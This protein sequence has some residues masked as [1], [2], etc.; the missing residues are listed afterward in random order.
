M[1]KLR[2]IMTVVALSVTTVAQQ[3]PQKHTAQSTTHSQNGTAKQ[4]DSSP[5][6]ADAKKS[7]EL[8]PPAPKEGQKQIDANKGEVDW[9]GRISNVITAVATL[10]LAVIGAIAACV[11]L[12]TLKEIQNQVGEMKGQRETME[13]QLKTMQS[14][15]AT[16]ERQTTHLETSVVVAQD[17]ASAARDNAIAAQEGSETA[18]QS[19][20]MFISKERARLRID[21]KP[22]KL[23]PIFGSIYAVD[24]AVC[25]YGATPAFVVE[26]RCTAHELPSSAIDEPELMDRAMLPMR[27][28]P[29]VMSPGAQPMESSAYLFFD[30]EAK[31]LMLSE[32]KADRFFVVVRGFIKYRDVF[33]C[34]RETKFRYVWKYSPYSPQT[35]PDRFGEWEK[36]GPA[37]DNIET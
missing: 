18:K 20:E 25:L 19:V 15:L 9:W 35:T 4:T 33:D 8:Q 2:L 16:M 1:Q 37:D 30:G 5:A 11:A 6:V 22:L 13:G 36:C 10:A 12:A 3:S 21:L 14:Q 23:S 31:D 17:A 34:D 24:F 26:A 27:S 7:I 29:S 28:V 32:I